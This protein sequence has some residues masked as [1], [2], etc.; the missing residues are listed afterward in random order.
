MAITIAKLCENAKAKYD[1]E[2]VAGKGGVE[3]T[4]RWVHMVEDKEVP[5]FCM[6]AS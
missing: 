2:L 1:M 5:T 3:N 6:A 4:V